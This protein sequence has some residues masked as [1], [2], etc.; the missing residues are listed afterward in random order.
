MNEIIDSYKLVWS[1]PICQQEVSQKNISEV[2]Q[3]KF[4]T[5]LTDFFG[6]DFLY[7]LFRKKLPMTFEGESSFEMDMG[8]DSD[9]TFPILF[10]SESDSVL[11]DFS[12][13]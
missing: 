4:Y 9:K 11:I 7:Y 13:K 5:N 2:R 8:I 3:F 12:L 6:V 1:S 10:E